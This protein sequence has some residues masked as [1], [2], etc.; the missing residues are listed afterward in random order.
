M[1]QQFASRERKK[2]APREHSVSGKPPPHL[3]HKRPH[4]LLVGMLRKYPFA[5]RLGYPFPFRLIS[6]VT[7]NRGVYILHKCGM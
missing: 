2:R 3:L 1:T 4:P 5:A 7:E 6:E